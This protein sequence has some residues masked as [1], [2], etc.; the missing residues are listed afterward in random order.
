MKA[1]LAVFTFGLFRKPADD[2]ANQGFYDRN[3]GNLAAVER[4]DGFIARSGYEDE[5][6]S[7][8][9]GRTGLSAHSTWSGATAGRRRRCLSGRISS[10][11]LPSPT[12]ATT[13][14]RCATGAP[15]SKMAT[16]HPLWPGGWT[17][18]TGPTGPKPWR[19]TSGSMTKDPGP[20]AFNFARPFNAAGEPTEIDRPRVK[21]QGRPQPAGDRGSDP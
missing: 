12:T 18:T 11:F 7:G 5:P 16:G 3:D 8:E 13:P 17:A 1:H 21:A 15:G 19:V 14:K 9:L 2:P 10:P 4:S 6:G 20:A